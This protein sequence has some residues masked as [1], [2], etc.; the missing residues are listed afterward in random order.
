METTEI[1][2]KIE[3][4]A[5]LFA[6][7]SKRTFEK[8]PQDGEKVI[9]KAMT[10]YGK[11]RGAR[12][13]G[14]A[15]A[16]GDH[17]STAMSQVYGEWVPDYDGQMDFGRMQTTP[18]LQT[19][20]AKCAWCDAWEKHNLM[21]YGKYYC[22]NIDNAWYQGF[23]PDNVCTQLTP[24]MSWGGQ[25]CEFDWQNPIT[26]EELIYLN[27]KKTALGDSCIKDFNFHTAHLLYS[28]SRTLKKELGEDATEIIENAKK[29]YINTFGQEYLDVLK[30]KYKGE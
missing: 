18:T 22:S 20:I 13:A 28:I 14:N 6:Y 10:I 16:N 24:P 1:N 5:V 11:E 30:G 19:Y 21:E 27:E 12:M 4:H 26:D 25:R 7:L 17:L 15:L 9:L 23:N 29:D 2:C 8:R 3:H